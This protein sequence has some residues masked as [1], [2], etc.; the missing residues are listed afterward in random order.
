MDFN[1]V[2]NKFIEL[3]HSEP[4]LY[5]SPG[6]INIIGEHTDYNN[7][8][9][10]PAAID[11][12]MIAAIAPN[13][14][15]KLCR[16]YAIDLEDYFE[17]DLDTMQPNEK[18]WPNYLMG[19]ADQIQ[20]KGLNISGFDCVF[21]GDVPLGAGLS[22]SAALECVAA[23]GLNDVFDLS[24]DN[25]EMILMAQMAEHTFAGVKCGI[26]DQFASVMGK[27]DKVFR[28]DCQTLEY[29]Y[30][31]IELGDY[32][33]LL[34]NTNVKHSLASSEYNTRRRE[35][36]EGLALVSKYHPEV[37][38]LRDVGSAMLESRKNE[39]TETV[40]R[41]CKYVLEENERVLKSCQAL[42]EGDIKLLGELIYAS[43]EGLSGEYEVSCPELDFLVEQTR[44]KS[45]IAGARMMGGGFGGC[46]INIIEKE[47][48]DIF[49]DEISHLYKKK[50]DLELQTI[51][52]SIE[53]GSSM[54]T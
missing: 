34:I 1:P 54:I 25:Q 52:V 10:L 30:Y 13:G 11:K 38:S 18:G 17:F 37:K 33:I 45:Y 35:C 22:S 44:D 4:G 23:F 49:I 16:L 26:M 47:K 6:R 31:P 24:L 20:K 19:V 51:M 39:M 14:Q 46:T 43:H 53:N 2:K 5:R 36:E 3:F 27:K 9:V 41:R 40:Y 15:K 12:E 7:G 29:S 48:A 32:Q 8:F 50:F 21:G 42:E 28:L